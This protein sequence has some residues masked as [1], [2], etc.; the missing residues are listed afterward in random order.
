MEQNKRH[1]SLEGAESI[2]RAGTNEL[3]RLSYSFLLFEFE[4]TAQV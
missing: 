3:A 1:A 4:M 2:G